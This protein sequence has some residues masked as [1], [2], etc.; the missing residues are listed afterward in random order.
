MGDDSGIEG[1]Y[2]RKSRA[3]Y[4]LPHTKQ[5]ATSIENTPSIAL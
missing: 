1:Y 3:I 5:D 4:A 2:R